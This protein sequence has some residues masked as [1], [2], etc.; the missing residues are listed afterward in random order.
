V[1]ADDILSRLLSLRTRPAPGEADYKQMQW[2]AGR[3]PQHY[4]MLLRH[5]ATRAAPAP[6]PSVKRRQPREPR[7]PHGEA[8]A[9]RVLAQLLA[10][11][12]RPKWGNGRLYHDMHHLKSK[13][14]GVW[15]MLLQNRPDWEF[16][17]PNKR[18]RTPDDV[19]VDALLKELLALPEPP[20]AGTP[21]YQK[22]YGLR[23][24]DPKLDAAL[25]L[26]RPD[27]Y[28]EQPFHRPHDEPSSYVPGQ[29]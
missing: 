13:Y 27:W 18:H 14:P 3:H 1:T 8:W 26:L 19:V 7:T 4:A 21:L 6:E 16:R 2:L 9:L 10:C 11:T 15:G 24:H 20:A 25:R 5:W 29:G 23:A 17:P 28:R 22:W 12:A